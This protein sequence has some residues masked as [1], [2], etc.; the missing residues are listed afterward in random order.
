VFRK[1]GMLG[2]YELVRFLICTIVLPRLANSS[3]ALTPLDLGY[4]T[5]FQPL[6]TLIEAPDGTVP[7]TSKLTSSVT[8]T[9]Y[10]SFTL[11][12]D[13][14]FQKNGR[15]G[16]YELVRFLICNKLLDIG[17]NTVAADM[18]LAST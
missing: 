9:Q 14:V 3:T 15:F 5:K 2:S 4:P 7:S 6:L 17:A 18:S 16:S 10:P 11:N 12:P 8:F 1:E 13:N